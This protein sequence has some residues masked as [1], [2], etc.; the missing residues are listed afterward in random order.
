[1][2]RSVAHPHLA[3]GWRTR[4]DR[5]DRRV[6]AVLARSGVLVVRLSLGVVFLW[7]G[8]LKFIP[9]PEPRRGPCRAD[10]RSD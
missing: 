5:I 2:S 4:I 3:S 6:T 10:D 7:F 8:A 1:M 9:G